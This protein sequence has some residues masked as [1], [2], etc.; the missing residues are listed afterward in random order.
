[1]EVDT[2]KFDTCRFRSD[3]E[4]EFGE[5]GCCGRAPLKGFTCLER[6]IEGLTPVVCERCEFYQ[7]RLNVLEEKFG[8]DQGYIYGEDQR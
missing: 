2:T 4:I 6:L 1:M 8:K 5:L 3:T 7:S